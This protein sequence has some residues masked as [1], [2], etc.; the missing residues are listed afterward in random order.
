MN[1]SINTRLKLNCQK[2]LFSSLNL[3]TF[4]YHTSNNHARLKKYSDK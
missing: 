3:T 2:V 4:I 1:K